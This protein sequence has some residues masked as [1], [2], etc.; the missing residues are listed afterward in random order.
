MDTVLKPEKPFLLFHGDAQDAQDAHTATPAYQTPTS[1]YVQY[2]ALEID[3]E[4]K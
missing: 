4:G 3:S 2:D 1:R